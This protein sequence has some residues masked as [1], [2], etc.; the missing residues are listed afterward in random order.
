[1]AAV[2]VRPDLN[3]LARID[4]LALIL[5]G[6]EQTPH[7]HLEVASNGSEQIHRQPLLLREKTLYARFANS[8]CAGQGLCSYGSL[9][10][11]AHVLV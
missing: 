11:A 5:E 8:H 9:P 1:M 10:T 6:D 4:D 3:H 7:W 2:S